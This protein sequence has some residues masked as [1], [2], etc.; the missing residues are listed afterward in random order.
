[1]NSLFTAYSMNSLFA[2]VEEAVVEEA[3][4]EEAVAEEAVVEEAVVATLIKTP[5]RGGL[6]YSYYSFFYYSFF[7]Y[8]FFYYSFFYYSF[9]YYSFFYYS[10]SLIRLYKTLYFLGCNTR[11]DFRSLGVRGPKG[12]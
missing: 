3:V 12:S 2:V 7:C 10:F 4:V 11:N 1:M 6:Y 9:F 8:S 5:P